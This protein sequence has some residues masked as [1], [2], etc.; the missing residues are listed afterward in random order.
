MLARGVR[1]SLICLLLVAP[2]LPALGDDAPLSF[3]FRVEDV[4]L[5]C[6][7]DGVGY[8][9]T[10]VIRTTVTNESDRRLILSREFSTGSHYR[11]ASSPTRGA[12]GDYELEFSAM[13][14][15]PGDA[16]QP[17]F[18][19]EPDPAR[20]V[21]VHPGST[22][23]TDVAQGLLAGNEQALAELAPGA[24]GGFVLP[25]SHALQT[26]IRTWPHI[27]VEW[28]T[29]ERLRRQWKPFGDLVTADVHTPF[30][31]FDLPDRMLQCDAP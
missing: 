19:P 8:P 5:G 20:F 18:G 28:G 11:V 6:S 4:R 31:W 24:D 1:L 27:F 14:V 17:E 15:A 25:G 16:P 10:L 26:T 22:Y 12:L 13:E 21:V 2:S 29:T 23:Q 30:L 3:E 7:E 9:V